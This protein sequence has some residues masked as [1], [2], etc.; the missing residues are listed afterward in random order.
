QMLQCC[1]LV[2]R[3]HGCRDIPSLALKKQ[4]HLLADPTGCPGD[5]NGF[6]HC[7]KPW[8]KTFKNQKKVPH[9]TK[10]S[11]RRQGI[12]GIHPARPASGRFAIDHLSIVDILYAL[13]W[14]GPKRASAGKNNSKSSTL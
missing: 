8:L 10:C 3:A 11:L 6:T 14:A 1:V 12:R 5:Q 2:R 13:S 7:C 9:S 4:R